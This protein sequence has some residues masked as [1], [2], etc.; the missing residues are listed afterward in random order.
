MVYCF[1]SFAGI[2]YS[3]GILIHGLYDVNNQ[4]T[5]DVAVDLWRLLFTHFQLLQV[6]LLLDITTSFEMIFE[7]DLRFSESQPKKKKLACFY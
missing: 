6:A 2:Y 1:I 7:H 3:S 4:F 5:P